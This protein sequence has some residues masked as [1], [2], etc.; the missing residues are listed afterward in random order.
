MSRSYVK[1]T[2]SITRREARFSGSVNATISGSS[3][4]SRATSTSAADGLAGV[5]VT[6]HPRPE[7]VPLPVLEAASQELPALVLGADAAEG[8]HHVRV[9][10]HRAV[11]VEVLLAEALP[12]QPLRLQPLDLTHARG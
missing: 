5:P 7:A 12:D 4:R 9:A 10:V 6:E 8:R 2:F 3:S 11:V 1:P